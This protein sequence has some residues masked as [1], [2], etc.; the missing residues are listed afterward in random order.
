MHALIALFVVVVTVVF[1][2]WKTSQTKY[3]PVCLTL[4][5]TANLFSCI[6]IL[7]GK[8]TEIIGQC[9]PCQEMGSGKLNHSRG[10]MAVQQN[11]SWKS[12]NCQFSYI[13]LTDN[14]S[15]WDSST[16]ARILTLTF[17]TNWQILLG[18]RKHNTTQHNTHTHTHSLIH[19]EWWNRNC[20]VGSIRHY[21]RDLKFINLKKYDK[22]TISCC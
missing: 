16:Q 4:W 2:V 19:H 15:A 20:E 3:Q 13:S 8:I 1:L 6:L 21:H 5:L 11:S 17:S 7:T 9:E 12:R 10:K 14:K 22:L 18:Y